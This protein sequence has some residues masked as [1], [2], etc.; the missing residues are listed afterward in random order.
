MLTILLALLAGQPKD[1]TACVPVVQRINVGTPLEEVIG[2]Y[3]HGGLVKIASATGSCR[4]TFASGTRDAAPVCAVAN[5]DHPNRAMQV[6][7]TAKAVSFIGGAK[8]DT[9]AFSCR[10]Y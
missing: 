3:D 9:L 5:R 7:T 8:G 2:T 4:F 1:A 6:V 10:W